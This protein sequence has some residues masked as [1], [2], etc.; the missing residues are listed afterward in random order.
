[1]ASPPSLATLAPVFP[2]GQ[3]DRIGVAGRGAGMVRAPNYETSPRDWAGGL[4]QLQKTAYY[5]AK[6]ANALFASAMR[7]MFVRVWIAVPSPL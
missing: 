6:W 7:C 3:D 4:G 1:M 5:Q 2:P